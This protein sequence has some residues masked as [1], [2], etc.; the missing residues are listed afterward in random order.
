MT[1]CTHLFKGRDNV[2]L[3]LRLLICRGLQLGSGLSNDWLT[4]VQ[5][6]RCKSRKDEVVVF[7]VSLMAAEA[8]FVLRLVLRFAVDKSAEAQPPVAAYFFESLTMI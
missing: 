7:H 5:P 8:R 2:P 4:H 6:S 3:S 1:D